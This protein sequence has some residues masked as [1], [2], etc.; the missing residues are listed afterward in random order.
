[1]TV[2]AADTDPV[3]GRDDEIDRVI[4]TLCRRTKSS[5]VLVGDPG[6]GKTAIAEGL[7]QRIPAGSVPA[8]LAGARVVEVDVPAMLAGTTYRGMFE[9]R[10]KGAI[11]EAEEADGKV[12]L[13]IDEM[14]TLLGAGRVKDSNMD[15]ANMLKPALA[16][17][18][19]RCIGAT[20][21]DEY[22]KYNENDAAFERRLQKV[23]VEESNTDATI[24]ILRGLK[25]RYEEHHDL[26]ILDSAI[27][28]AAQLAA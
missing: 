7:A 3:I 6:V 16:R 24:A 11:K 4:C 28:A 10:M 20:T 13:F 14:H 25:Q 5:A 22:R 27:V 21:F 26:R 8:N 9:E 1:M 15:A 17:G 12:I 19:I 2:A 18:R 23:H